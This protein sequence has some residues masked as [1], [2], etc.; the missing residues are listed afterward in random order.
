MYANFEPTLQSSR[1]EMLQ[2]LRQPAIACSS[3]LLRAEFLPYFYRTHVQFDFNFWFDGP[4]FRRQAEDMGKWLSSIGEANRRCLGDV[5]LVTT[6]ELADHAI[7]TL[8]TS[9]PSP[10]ELEEATEDLALEEGS[11][12][13]G[14]VIYAMMFI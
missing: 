3:K 2:T 6:S 8:R 5:D 13:D 4:Y 11:G 9:L 12:L 1:I 10:L 14:E 7:K